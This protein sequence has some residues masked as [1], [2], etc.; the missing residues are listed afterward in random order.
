MSLVLDCSPAL[1][2][3]YQDENSPLADDIMQRVVAGGAWV[4]SIWRLEIANGLRTGLRHDRIDAIE[5]DRA[6]LEL[7]RLNIRTDFDTDRQAWGATLRL[8]DQLGLT[9]YDASY[10]ELA[11][12]LLLPIGSLDHRLCGAARTLG[13]PV[14]GG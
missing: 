4:T 6:I 11:Q 9:P 3:F 2:W 14:V 5:R 8:S 12:R 1:A 7:G 10:L 13:V